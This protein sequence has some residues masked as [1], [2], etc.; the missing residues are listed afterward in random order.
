MHTVKVTTIR[1]DKGKSNH[2]SSTDYMANL[3]LI[4]GRR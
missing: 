3:Q 4:L 2:G 1:R